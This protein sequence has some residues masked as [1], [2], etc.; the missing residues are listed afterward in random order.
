MNPS[1]IDMT[2]EYSMYPHLALVG[3]V[4]NEVD[5]ILTERV[6]DIT[7]GAVVTL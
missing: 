5:H 2:P 6:A 1:V 4:T 7:E 3:Q